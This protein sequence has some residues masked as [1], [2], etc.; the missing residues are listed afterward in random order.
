AGGHMAVHRRAAGE[1]SMTGRAVRLHDLHPKRAHLRQDVIDGLSATPRVLPAKYFYDETGA[2]LF[3]RIT[4]LPEYY[5]TRTELEILE[6]NSGGIARAVGADVHL[7]EFGSGSG[8]KTR[9]LL[10][11][12]SSPA[13]YSPVDISREQLI[14]FA[15]SIAAELDTLE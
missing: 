11:A 9:L 13:A 10:R 3:D 12:L 4:R 6:R 14:D 2:A 5:P 7:I 8:I 15:T 1:R